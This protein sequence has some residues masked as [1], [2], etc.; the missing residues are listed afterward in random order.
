MASFR[1]YK[2]PAKQVMQG[3]KW[4]WVQYSNNNEDFYKNIKKIW[5]TTNCII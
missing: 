4:Q 2:I 1:G 5:K 3:V